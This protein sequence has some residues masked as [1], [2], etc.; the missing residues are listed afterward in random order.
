MSDADKCAAILQGKKRVHPVA[1]SKPFD[2]CLLCGYEFNSGSMY[3][4][5]NVTVSEYFTVGSRRKP[6]E[7]NSI[8]I[9]CTG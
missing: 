6:F 4:K 5:W 3:D 9:W 2:T 1:D 8:Y 7:H